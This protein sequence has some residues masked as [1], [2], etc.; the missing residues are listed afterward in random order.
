[1]DAL[2]GLSGVSHIWQHRRVYTG[3]TGGS[4]N[5]S[6]SESTFWKC[7]L[8]GGL[9][10]V[11]SLTLVCQESWS[12]TQTLS[13]CETNV[14]IHTLKPLRVVG[15]DLSVKSTEIQQVFT[16]Y[17]GGFPNESSPHRT[18]KL[19]KPQVW[20]CTT[21]TMWTYH[22][23]EEVN[24]FTTLLAAVKAFPVRTCTVAKLKYRQ[25]G[26]KRASYGCI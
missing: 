9:A 12:T 10:N 19:F 21:F 17:V 24:C 22:M 25:K 26:Q 13:T 1:M 23:Y 11:S 15:F 7:L 2:I 5:R 18:N 20:I 6:S 3:H 4:S 8:T 14:L 16:K